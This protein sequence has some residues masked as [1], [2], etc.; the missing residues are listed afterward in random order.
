MTFTTINSE[1][2]HISEEYIN[3]FCLIGVYFL[4]GYFLA[5]AVSHMLRDAGIM[6][7]TGIVSAV[8]G[9]A[10][11]VIAVVSWIGTPRRLRGA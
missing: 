9:G 2:G 10:L 8:A 4:L 7:V 3:Y 5:S 11:A 6:D 1:S